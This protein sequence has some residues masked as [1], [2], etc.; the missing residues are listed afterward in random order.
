M[1][2]PI[3]MIALFGFSSMVMAQEDPASV[4]VQQVPV[5]QYSYSTHLDVAKV[6]SQ[7]EVA[8][9]CGVVPMRMTYE[10]SQGKR[11]ILAYEVMGSGC[12]NG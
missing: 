3:V 12:S 7:T 11:H 6:I 10:D 9:V 8:D 2:A 1:K 4:Q 5:E